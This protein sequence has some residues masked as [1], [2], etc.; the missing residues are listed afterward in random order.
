MEDVIDD[1]RSLLQ[2]PS[3]T[4]SQ[5]RIC[6]KHIR[7]EAERATEIHAAH[8]LA[9]GATEGAGSNGTRATSSRILILS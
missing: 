5:F 1:Q 9:V 6:S 7:L 4:H 3:Y 8:A 2:Y